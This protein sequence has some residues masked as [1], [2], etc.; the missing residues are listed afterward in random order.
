MVGNSVLKCNLFFIYAK[1]LFT[2]TGVLMSDS[3][4]TTMLRDI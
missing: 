2:H 1:S 3:K 4:S